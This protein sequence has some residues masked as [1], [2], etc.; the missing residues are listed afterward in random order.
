[1][2][3]MEQK[4]NRGGEENGELDCLSGF[5]FG[6][7]PLFLFKSSTWEKKQLCVCVRRQLP[8]QPTA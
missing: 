5:L 8:A 4:R 3:G 6:S 2:R 1:M 7:V